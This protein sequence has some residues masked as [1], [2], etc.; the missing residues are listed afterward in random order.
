MKAFATRETKKNI[1]GLMMQIGLLVPLAFF[2]GTTA[3]S[4]AINFFPPTNYSV[5]SSAYGITTGDFNEDGNKDMAVGHFGGTVIQILLG[6]G[7]GGFGSATNVTIGNLPLNL[8]VSD[9]NGDSHQDIVVANSNV[10]FV[11]VIFGDGTGGFGVPIDIPVGSITFGV[12]VGDFN[13]DG[14][15]DIVASRNQ[16]GLPHGLS[17]LLG[18]GS[19]G[20]GAATDYLVPNGPSYIGVRDVNH[21]GHEDLAVACQNGNNVSVL[22]GNGSGVFGVVTNFATQT[23]PIGVVLEDFNADGNQDIAATNLLSNSVSILLGNGLGSFGSS[24]NFGTGGQ[25]FAIVSNDFNNDG[26]MDV[27]VTN[28]NTNTVGLLAGDGVGGLGAAVSFGVGTGPRGI[29]LADFNSDGRKDLATANI[30]SS[31]VSV[32]LFDPGLPPPS[33]SS[34]SPNSGPIGTT[35]T[36][37]GTN[38][39]TT[40][41]NNIVYFGATKA[42][43]TAA[44]ATQLTVTVPVG[45]TYQPI[46]VQVAGLTA[47]SSKPFIVTFTGGGTIEACSFAP[48]V[49]LGTTGN[50][51]RGTL[52]D[53]DGDGKPDLIIPAG[54]GFSNISIYRNISTTGTI[55][56]GSFA[57]AVNFTTGTDPLSVSFGDLD[58]DGKPDLA[59]I[60]ANGGGISVFKNL[61]TPGTIALAAKVDFA[62]SGATDLAISDIDGDGK[63]DLSVT[64]FSVGFTVLRNIGSTGVINASTFAAGVSFGA[65]ANP[66]PFSLGDI[67]GDGKIDVAVPDRNAYTVSVL[68]NTSVPGTVSFAALVPLAT[69]PGTPA[70]GQGAAWSSLGDIDG[71]SKMDLFVSNPNINTVAIFRN[72]SSAGLVSFAARFDLGTTFWP[73]NPTQSDLDGDGKIDLTVD[74]GGAGVNTIAIY[75]STSTSGIINAST[76]AAPVT[77]ATPSSRL[78]IAGDIDGDGRNELVSTYGTVAVLRNVIGTLAAPSVS[79]F[80]PGSGASGTSVTITGT[81]FSTPFSN[82]V[83]FNGVPGT[84]T[85]STATTLTVTVPVG[86]TS[87]PLD[88]TIGCNTLNAGNF[89]FP[90]TITLF[91]PAS[92]P[93]GT[94]VTITGTN[95]NPTPANNIVFFGATQATVT[96]ATSTQLTATVLTGA[97]Y[98]PISVLVNGLTAYSSSPFVVT[99]L[100]GGTTDACSFAPNVSFTTGTNARDVAFGDLDGDG[101]S[102][103]VVTNNNSSSVSVFLNTSSSGSITSGSFAAKVDFA[104]GAFA[105]SVAI[106]DLDGDGKKD[107]AITNFNSN[108]VSIFRNTSSLGSITSGS[109][110]TRVDFTTG[111]SPNEVAISDVD[112][113]GKPD[114]AVANYGNNTVSVFLNTSSSGSITTGSFAAKVDFT[115][116]T[117]ARDVAFGDLDGDGKPD[118]V[119]ANR[120]SNSVSVLR[121]TSVP[122]SITSGSFAAIVDFAT[123][124]E[125]VELAIGDLDM[126][127]KQDLVVTNFSSNSLSVFRNLSSVGSI[128]LGAKVDFTTGTNPHDIQIGDLDGDG[129]PDLAVS[130]R[131]SS[132]ISAFR[133]TSTPG[134]ITSGSFAAKV[135]FTT[136]TLPT[137]LAIGDLDGDNKPDLVATNHGSNVMWVLRNTIGESPIPTITSFTPSSGPIGTSITITGTNFDLIPTNNDVKFNGTAAVVTVSTATSITTSVPVGT[138]AGTITVKVGCNTATSSGSFTV[139]PPLTIT[140]FSPTSGP[141]GTTVTITGTNFSATP[142][143]N[144]VFFGGTKATVTAATTTQLTVTVPTGATYQPIS[145]LVAGLTAY[146]SSPFV[147]TF[148]GGGTIDACSL[149]PKV[150]FI[151]GATPLSTYIGD[152]DGDGKADLVT[153]NQNA[154]TISVY[155]NTSSTGVVDVTSFSAKVDFAVGAQPYLV[156][157]GDIDGDSKP[158]LVTSNEVGNI[159]VLRNTSVSGTINASSFAVAVNFTAGVAP[160]SV[161]L[162]DL[163]ADGKPELVTANAISN[164]LSVLKNTSV[165]GTISA[166]SF[167][168]KVD[169]GTG[170]SPQ[171]VVI[172]DLDGDGKPDLAVTNGS[173]G[174]NT[175]SVLR[176]TT[177]IGLID[178]TSFAVKVDFTTG[179]FPR[180]MAVG[181][182]DADGKPDLAVA[183][184]SSNT[185]SVLRNTSSPGGITAGSF[186]TKVDFVTASGPHCVTIGDIDGD[187]KPDLAV[188]NSGS[189]SI[190]LFKNISLTGSITTGSF[191]SRIDFVTALAPTNLAIGDLEGDGKPEV[192]VGVGGNNFVSVFHNI[193]GVPPPVPVSPVNGSSCGPGTVLLSVSGAAPGQYRWYDAPTGGTAI[194]GEVNAS[195]TTGLLST[196]TTY[197]TTISINS[198][199]SFARTPVTATIESFPVPPTTPVNGVRCGPGSTIVTVSGASA[200]QYRWYTAPTGGTALA[201][202]TNANYT[203]PV[204][205]STTPYYASIHNGTCESATRTAVDAIVNP[206]PS[207]PATPTVNG[208]FCSGSTFTFTTSGASPGEYRWYTVPSGGTPIAGAVNDFYSTV[209]TTAP[210]PT[211]YVLIVSGGCESGRQS[212]TA[213]V[214]PLPTSPGVATPAPVCSGNSVPITA[215]GA[216]NGQYRWYDGGAL[217]AGEF[218][219]VLTILSLT[220]AKSLE[221]AINDGTCEST[222]TTVTATVQVCTA[223]VI[224]DNVSAPFVPGIV[225][226]D[227]TPLLSDA[228]G[229]LDVSSI[230]IVGT[231]ASGA[232]ATID[233]TD[234]VIDYTG[235]P[236][237][238]IETVELSVCDLTGL[239]TTET[240]TVELSSEIGIYN[241]LSPNGD[242]KNETFFI[243]NIDKLADTKENKVMIFNRWGDVVFSVENY[244][245]LNRVFVG[246]NNQGES[247]PAGTY[248][249]RIDFKNGAPSRTGFLALK[250]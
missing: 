92:G 17:I 25:P 166:G 26:K 197:Y 187:G 124:T 28:R 51:H 154:N 238:G 8:A 68:R 57:P 240:L 5:T 2:G 66:F 170:S 48:K 125:P 149:A 165:I 145:V 29:A 111:T 100:G 18:D 188:A 205:A 178:A 89:V 39:S 163:D 198:C 32:L 36:I 35:V 229:N 215:S 13:E 62:V 212:V 176:N 21:D 244:D 235:I 144:I 181:D 80:S 150:D 220:A 46:T 77:L 246:L 72:T 47:Y 239:C 59:T 126:D 209:L 16:S 203:T 129:K 193:V 230:S 247:I 31:N 79:S 157:I 196:S 135:D 192:V 1:R 91:A 24:T 208:P 139:T 225:R 147:V 101:K 20:F 27:A 237:P 107:L 171:S 172:T 38:F 179:F 53:V 182:L 103:L 71:D 112:G 54:Q 191:S 64:P 236:F 108:S 123:G 202:E 201:G 131:S 159:S 228:E 95:F 60:S 122:G 160:H 195:Y 113:D 97:T 194:P 223:P 12:S 177:T 245:N 50:M 10:G 214:I 226:I 221:V 56:P 22:L 87:G 133:N 110:A 106:G 137:G 65:G 173:G 211:Y 105:T 141:I 132:N 116:G 148:P 41:A 127:G 96:A 143:N 169:F 98:H 86:A 115:V 180:S 4:Q 52:G 186:A 138:I 55:V 130:N 243:E 58:S 190:G 222:R 42:T 184:Y 168:A 142:S 136:G 63:Q 162:G 234:L 74:L 216:V 140:S 119:A 76:F 224:A 206:I 200:G 104:T 34:F 109:F 207:D 146:S 248:F 232:T 189:S 134:S 19:G 78:F 85:G 121:N 153:G 40:P 14:K 210:T 250:K 151:T 67:D 249:F 37:T 73:V 120:L 15:K 11:S 161:A 9:F 30:S 82:S 204:I 185:L 218:N 75:K 61:S 213:L 94:T 199:E 242:G 156:V 81:N 44:T 155:R 70:V 90:P 83:T 114:L 227:L 84:I 241:A 43:V 152:L 45:A 167:A 175:L 3:Y 99:F 7:S 69:A 88:V 6:N 33:I 219:S 49:N 158:D 117:S 23:N 233:G 102:D 183:N 118:L 128:S 93:V 217:I 164:T 174:T 231:L